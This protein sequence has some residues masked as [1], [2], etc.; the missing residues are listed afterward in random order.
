MDFVY[1]RGNLFNLPAH[2][3]SAPFFRNDI[4]SQEAWV[5]FAVDML[6]WALLAGILI[7]LGLRKMWFVVGL[8]ILLIGIEAWLAVLSLYAPTR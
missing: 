7:W 3:A 8:I 1:D 4:W 2:I 5:I 6:F